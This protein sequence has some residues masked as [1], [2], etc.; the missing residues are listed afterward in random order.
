MLRSMN[1]RN[2]SVIANRCAK[3]VRSSR[4]PLQ[5]WPMGKSGRTAAGVQRQ[6]VGQL[7]KYRSTTRL[8]LNKCS[9]YDRAPP[10]AAALAA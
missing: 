5:V 9:G 4:Q 2:R 10:L 3:A 1:G 8:R 7:L 6:L